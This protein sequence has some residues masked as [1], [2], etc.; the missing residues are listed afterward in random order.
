MV[1]LLRE[2][3]AVSMMEN[4]TADRVRGGATFRAWC[5]NLLHHWQ[6]RGQTGPK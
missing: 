6:K 3:A 4:G 5:N 1:V 2:A